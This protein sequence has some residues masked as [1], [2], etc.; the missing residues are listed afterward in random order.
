MS[1]QRMG[2][3]EAIIQLIKRAQ[4]MAVATSQDSQDSPQKG[5]YVKTIQRGRVTLTI[6]NGKHN[7]R[8][9]APCAQSK[10][11]GSGYLYLLDEALKRDVIIDTR[12]RIKLGLKPLVYEAYEF[13][14][15]C[16]CLSEKIK[17]EKRSRSKIPPQYE[18]ANLNDFRIDIYAKPESKKAAEIVKQITRSYIKNY[19]KLIES[20]ESVGLFLFSEAK[21]SGKTFTACAVANHLIAVANLETRFY[22]VEE[23]LEDIRATYNDKSETSRADIMNELKRVDLLILDEI[24]I[25]SESNFVNRTL[26]E[27]IDYRKT[28]RKI[29]IF[30]SN[31]PVDRL[32]DVYQSDGG[33][34]GRRVQEMTV[35]LD[36]PEENVTPRQTDAKTQEAFKILGLGE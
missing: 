3:S 7:E 17:R 18:L 31:L 16:P 2:D 36:F 6:L 10:C 12:A 5:S 11:D 27:L 34:I 13:Q 33:R 9:T 32:Q 23:L 25:G 1:M 8:Y 15:P 20:M 26:F 28:H 14:A 29:T 24:G 4:Q 22:V 21:G 19:T 30:T 35:Q